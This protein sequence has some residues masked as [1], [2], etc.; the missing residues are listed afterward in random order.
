MS[1]KIRRAKKEDLKK[2]AELFLIETSK[3]PYVQGWTRI[4]SLEKIKELFKS[5]II[6]VLEIEEIVGF[7]TIVPNKKKKEIYVDELWISK[8]YQGKGFG[9]MLMNFVEK[10]FKNKGMKKITLM[11]NQEAGAVKFYKKLNYKIKHQFIYFTKDL[12]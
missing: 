7:I 6:F 3:K 11:A 10:T 2:I 4:T 9:K 1:V 8:E 12:V 5:E